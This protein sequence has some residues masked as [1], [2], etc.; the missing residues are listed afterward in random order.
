[1]TG[2]ASDSLAA[3]QRDTSSMALTR[4]SGRSSPWLS[5]HPRARRAT[6]AV[7]SARPRLASS[8][9][10]STGEEKVSRPRTAVR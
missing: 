6:S 4:S 3:V 7:A 2:A 10:L 9:R 8:L 5:S 1:M